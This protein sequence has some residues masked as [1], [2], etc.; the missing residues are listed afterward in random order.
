[1]TD[2]HAALGISQLNKLESFIEARTKIAQI[3][4]VGLSQSTLTLPYQHSDAKSSYH[5]YPVR[6][7]KERSKHSQLEIY[8]GMRMNSIGVNL[9]YI[10]VYRHPYY[11]KLGFKS[12]YCPESENY[13]R[14]TVS[15]PI[16]PGLLQEAQTSIIN[17][18]IG[19][20]KQ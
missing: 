18:L 16:F 20:I 13:F 2:L 11:T 9:H 14:E 5:L 15:L 8:S 1:M 17:T 12:G 7:N 4:D 3:Y 6:I 10:P 19:L